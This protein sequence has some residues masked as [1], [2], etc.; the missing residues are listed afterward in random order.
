[1]VAAGGIAAITAAL[2]LSVLLVGL[3][4]AFH[5]LEVGLPRFS[6]AV[7]LACLVV[8]A[9]AG[10]AVVRPLGVAGRQAVAVGVMGCA[11][12]YLP[13][14]LLSPDRPDVGDWWA[15]PSDAVATDLVA[16]HAPVLLLDSDESDQPWFVGARVTSVG[17]RTAVEYWWAFAGNRS[18]SLS[19]A[20][21]LPALAVRRWTCFDHDGDL[22]G[23]TVVLRDGVPQSVAY[24]SHAGVVP[25]S[26]VDLRR[27]GGREGPRPRV[28]V[29]L[30]SHASY[31]GPCR[32]SCR[33]PQRGLFGMRLSEGQ[34]DGARRAV[35]GFMPNPEPNRQCLLPALCLRGDE[36]PPVEQQ[37]RDTT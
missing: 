2:C 24:A 5:A 26:W 3:G 22:E 9:A 11:A 37:S 25:I 27:T 7:G 6:F 18:P 13:A 29:A 4:M 15:A 1:L 33:R 34:H 35:M 14:V 28:Y 16:R 20:A 8:A 36:P 17:A 21:C 32:S 19:D 31:P 30:G 23:V 12:V 10:S